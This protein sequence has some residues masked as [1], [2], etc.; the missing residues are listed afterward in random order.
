[1]NRSKLYLVRI[2]QVRD[3]YRAD[4]RDVASEDTEV[5]SSRDALARFFVERA[6]AQPSDRDESTR[7]APR[8]PSADTPREELS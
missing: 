3:G 8:R 6:S 7:P 4:V 2:W 1:M 5:F